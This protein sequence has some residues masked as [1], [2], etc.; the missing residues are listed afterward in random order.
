MILLNYN[1]QTYNPYLHYDIRH[2]IEIYQ[3]LN[4]IILNILKKYNYKT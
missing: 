3:I 2:S 1:Y 4:L